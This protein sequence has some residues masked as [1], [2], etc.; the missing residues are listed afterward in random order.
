MTVVE[1]SIVNQIKDINKGLKR[2]FVTGSKNFRPSR[3]SN[4]GPLG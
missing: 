3:G 2:K 1:H 4:P